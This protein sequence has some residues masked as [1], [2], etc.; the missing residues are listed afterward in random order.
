MVAILSN[1]QCFRN[2]SWVATYFINECLEVNGD[3]PLEVIELVARGG[4]EDLYVG[5]VH[6][7]AI[8]L[9]LNVNFL[10]YKERT[11]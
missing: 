2:K 7:D 10:K 6:I 4:R 1:P 3:C 9:I 5:Q 8:Q 11:L